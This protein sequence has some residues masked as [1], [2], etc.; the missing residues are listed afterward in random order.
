LKAP[1]EADDRRG[2]IKDQLQQRDWQVL[3][4]TQLRRVSIVEKWELMG[5]DRNFHN[6]PNY[7]YG[8]V[9]VNAIHTFSVFFICLS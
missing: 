8:R 7:K 6:R 2:R 1:F 4:T 5:I 9:P 3:A